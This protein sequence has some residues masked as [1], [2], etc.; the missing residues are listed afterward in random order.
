MEKQEIKITDNLWPVVIQKS[1]AGKIEVSCPFFIDCKV[2]AEDVQDA[3]VKIESKI[4]RK[5]EET[6]TTN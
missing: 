5:I 3:M 6:R 2:E 1:D 4:T